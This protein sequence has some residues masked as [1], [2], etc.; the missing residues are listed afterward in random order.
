[1][2]PS[3]GAFLCRTFGS[4]REVCVFRADGAHNFAPT[5]SRT[6]LSLKPPSGR[7]ILCQLSSE[8]S[9]LLSSL[10]CF[11]YLVAYLTLMKFF[12]STAAMFT[13]TTLSFLARSSTRAFRSP[14]VTA[15]GI[16]TTSLRFAEEGQAEVVLVG[17]GAPNRGMG[18]YHAVQML[19]KK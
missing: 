8:A 4:V 7:K 16:A 15:R 9:C 6:T 13:S 18:W 3:A 19:E 1:M 12:T 11:P 14:S 10:S 17:C 2:K 5:S